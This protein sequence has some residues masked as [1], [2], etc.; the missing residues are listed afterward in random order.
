MTIKKEISVYA[1]I[2]IIRHQLGLDKPVLPSSNSIFKGLP[3][4]LHPSYIKHKSILYVQNE[5]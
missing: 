3:S 4:C 2:I 5:H 1:I